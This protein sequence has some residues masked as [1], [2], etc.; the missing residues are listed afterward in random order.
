M[1]D[2]TGAQDDKKPMD[3]ALKPR[4]WSEHIGQARMKRILPIQIKAAN[5]RFERLGHLLL[6]GD[7]G[8]GK[9][10]LAA[11]VAQETNDHFLDVMITPNFKISALNTIILEL[12]PD[13]THM[14]L[15]DEIHNLKPAQQHYLY[16]ILQ[17]SMIS[18]DSGKKTPIEASITFIGATT[19]PGML[20]QSMYD[21]FDIVHR[22]VKYTNEEMAEI[23]KI[24]AKRT[25]VVVDDEQAFALGRAA[26]G[27]PRQARSLVL[28]ARDLGTSD[29]SV[30][31]DM[32]GV[33]PDGLTQDHVSYLKTLKDLGGTAGIE[34]LANHSGRSKEIIH[35]IEKLLVDRE[36]IQVGKGGRQMMATG[37]KALARALTTMEE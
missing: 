12:D 3:R 26:A 6:I 29:P 20:T 19:E 21:R 5:D 27:T 22:F 8:T 14:I 7:P 34:N 16:S 10:S 24:L 23:V 2:N 25:G 4:K 30:V 15:L 37:S 33:T 17:E 13:E 28:A 36:Y 9:S 32:V 1:T 11:L 31:F 18:H 35:K